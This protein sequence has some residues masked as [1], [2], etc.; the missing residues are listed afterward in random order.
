VELSHPC[1]KEL[2][3]GG[4]KKKKI[5]SCQGGD[6]AAPSSWRALHLLIAALGKDLTKPNIGFD[7]EEP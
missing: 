2:G 3:G 1:H 6:P 5:L 4:S 7:F